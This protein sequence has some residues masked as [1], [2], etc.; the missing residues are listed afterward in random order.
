MS[1]IGKFRNWFGNILITGK[2]EDVDKIV[3]GSEPVRSSEPEVQTLY[4]VLSDYIDFSPEDYP[5]EFVKIVE[6]LTIYNEDCSYALDNIVQLSNT[7]MVESFGEDVGER[8]AKEL[9]QHI[10]D[11]Q[12]V[13]YP[14]GG[15]ISSLRADLIRQCV[16]YGA[17][18]IE[19]VPN[20]NL[21]GVYKTIVV[22]PST[23]VFKY[24]KETYEWL[25]YQRTKNTATKSGSQYIPLNPQTFKYYAIRRKG[26]KP[27]GISP[28]LSVLDSMTIEKD[29]VDNIKAVVKNLGVIGF[30]EVLVNY[31]DK[32]V[33]EGGRKETPK[34]YE[35]R[36]KSILDE[37]TDNVKDGMKNGFV[38]GFKNQHEF[39]ISSASSNVQGAAELVKLNTERKSA[40]LK[41][42]P[43]MLGRSYSTTETLGAVVLTL[44]ASS[45]KNY[46][47]LIDTVIED[48]YKFELALYKN[49]VYNVSVESDKPLI[50]DQV[51]D[52][53]AQGLKIDNLDK[54]YQ[55][56]VISQTQRAKELGYDK[57]DQE[58]PRKSSEPVL[59][60]PV[61]E[62][63]NG[64]KTS[65]EEDEELQRVLVKLGA[66][67][68]EF[69]YYYEC[70]GS[71][72][73]HDHGS[74]SYA[75][76]DDDL[77]E[78]YLSAYTGKTKQLYTKAI[79][80][81][82]KKIAD[83]FDNLP[84]EISS[85]E[86]SRKIMLDIY[87]SWE[88]TFAVK[89]KEVIAKYVAGAYEDF[90]KDLKVF[91]GKTKLPNGDKIPAAV[92][93]T[94]DFRTM[95]YVES[96]DTFYLGKFITDQDV[97]NAITGYIKEQYIADQYWYKDE[98][99]LAAFQ[100]Q[101]PEVL[102]DK[103][104]KIESILSTT[105][106]RLR[107]YASINYMSQAGVTEYIIL[108]VND[109]LQC[110]FCAGMQEK[111]FSVSTS[112]TKIDNTVSGGVES[113][114]DD[115]PFITTALSDEVSALN[116]SGEQRDKAIT[117]LVKG[118]SSESLVLKGIDAPP[119]HPNCRDQVV[120]KI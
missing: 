82:M 21:D 19:R 87:T 114:P 24:D 112:L 11:K 10:K 7:P 2:Q 43:F 95:A 53:T 36:V 66:Y 23:I 115:S 110:P 109:Q 104:W 48:I 34:E 84:D 44:L 41:Q 46:Q 102:K 8:E 26:E 92:F 16:I 60:E 18:A 14:G 67:K 33:H 106:N 40:G 54:L 89:E 99:Q 105:M 15:G 93:N 85:D 39:K 65:E 111:V 3:K 81:I 116:V 25:P 49:T 59:E 97:Q 58:E 31:P 69:D 119:Y 47:N 71:S 61:K 50:S 77:L 35:K 96:I 73:N 74:K 98:K 63:D 118:M 20:N 13:W 101:F 100:K 79:K 80:S 86:L 55:Q 29:M 56:G 52:A 91:G 113:L 27:Y 75:K 94:L 103:S 30:L 38:V 83:S 62:G 22:D 117:A 4:S 72:C 28:F 32:I 68:K 70:G 1:L 42:S 12:K 37:T 51:K 90:R 108:G 17:I 64:T 107:N 76:G 9:A 88:D 57:P 6:H 120:A 45:V 5:V 78:E